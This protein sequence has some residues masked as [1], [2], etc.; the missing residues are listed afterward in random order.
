MNGERPYL[1]SLAGANLP[2]VCIIEQ[3]VLFQLVLH[4]G[5]RKLGAKDGNLEFSQHP[6]QTC[7]FMAMGKHDGLTRCRFSMR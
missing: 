5:Q 7:V 2:Q 6:G 4:I 3:A 1:R